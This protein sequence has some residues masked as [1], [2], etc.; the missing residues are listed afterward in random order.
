MEDLANLAARFNMQVDQWILREEQRHHTDPPQV[1][2]QL[3]FIKPP[4]YSYP[5]SSSSDTRSSVDLGPISTRSLRAERD[6]RR[7]AADQSVEA[8]PPTSSTRLRPVLR[9]RAHVE[10]QHCHHD[11][12]S[13]QTRNH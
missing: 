12:A 10:P 13:I 4:M 1:R 7:T 9:K 5:L 6:R 8:L 11:A 3:C 2:F